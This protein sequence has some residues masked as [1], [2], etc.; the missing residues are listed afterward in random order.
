MQNAA[1]HPAIIDAFLAAN[2]RWQ[3]RPNLLPLL[4]IQPKQ[5]ASHHPTPR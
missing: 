1:D 2:V 3:K 5:V 4:V